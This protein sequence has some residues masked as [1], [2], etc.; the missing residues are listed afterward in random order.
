MKNDKH[1][2]T[3]KQV[4]QKR[5]DGLRY[6]FYGLQVGLLAGLV[7]IFYRLLLGKAEDALFFVVHWISGNP[8]RIGGWFL[9]LIPL[10]LIVGLIAKWEPMS[11]G[12]GIPQV[13]GEM[14]GHLNPVWWRVLLAK[15]SGGSLAILGG[16]SLGREGPSIQL[17][18]MAAKGIAKEFRL[19]G[20]MERNLISC[21]AGAG[22][23]AAFNAP[24]A[25]I[26]FVLEEI[27]RTFDRRVLA[28]GLV[29]AVVADYLSKLVFGQ[30][31]IFSYES[32][33]MN[34]KNYWLL[35]IL[36]ILL[37]VA[38]V[39][40]NLV[41]VKGQ[42]W[43]GRLKKIPQPVKVM[44]PFLIAGVLAVYLPEVLG[45]GHAMVELLT[46]EQ[47]PGLSVLVL[48]LLAKFLFSVV[49]F[50]SGAPGGI[51]F[52]LLILG[53]YIGAIFGS[54][55]VPLLGLPEDLIQKFIILAMAGIFASIV[56]AP[57]TG[58]V[59]IAEMTGSM[60]S[61]I[62]IVVVSM[63]SYLVA[64]LLGNPPIYATLL[65]RILAK[66]PQPPEVEEGAEK[67]LTSYIVPVGSPAEGRA[68]R[69]IPWHKNCLVASIIREG[70]T[71]TPKGDTVIESGD[72]LLILIARLSFADDS[73]FIDRL[74]YGD[75]E[76]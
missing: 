27:H 57:I 15:I 46:A 58:I 1:V 76:E 8:L 14:R 60:T 54:I 62:D 38:G 49:S 47:I 69:D 5:T 25:G 17:G 37:G 51:F 24:L 63:I 71:L 33:V 74:I 30:S 36:G 73:T 53:S 32:P 16:L 9:C 64:N 70:R 52:P 31:T 42:D 66:Q 10:G 39:V 29:A 19:D 67:L 6:V 4:E 26:L 34:L 20:T 55:V 56:R 41:M 7:A 12:S 72:E 61:L 43:F 22:L 68:I 75:S 50:G 11:A 18:A 21:G 44:I 48:L 45:G 28:M 2:S 65:E 35:V 23:A 40:Y 59:L 3:L 13:S